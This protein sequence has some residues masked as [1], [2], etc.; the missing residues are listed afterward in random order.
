[1]AT[2]R[3]RGVKQ[4]QAIVRRAGFTVVTKTFETR[5]GAELWGAEVE[6]KMLQGC[7][8]C[9]IDLSRI[10]LGD[11]LIRYREEVAPRHKG[12]RVEKYRI[13][14]LL[15]HPISE[16]FLNELRASHF[17]LYRDEQLKKIK[18]STL[19]KNL[20]QFNQAIETARKEW[21]LIDIRNPIS[22]IRKPTVKNNRSRRLSGHEEEQLLQAF[23]PAIRQP[24]GTYGP[25]IRN[26]FM[27]PVFILAIETAARR[28]ELLK[29]TWNQVDLSDGVAT[30][31][32]TKNGLDREIPLTKKAREILTELK[33]SSTGD[34]VFETTDEAIKLCWQRVIKNLGIENLHFHDL[35]HEAISR[36]AKKV[37]NLIELSKISGHQD[38]K[39]L[40]RYYHISARELVNK[41]G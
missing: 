4:W 1:M 37:P 13:N 18:P 41:I 25:G 31:L 29:L 3:K 40:S 9:S 19:L 35:R 5:L 33:K 34:K 30:F 16:V 39:M 7:Q 17:A 38:L 36:L 6:K 24:D 15:R 23:E 28:G 12:H 11:L 8:P 32:D 20:G 27:K 26:Q 14:G 21:D 10:T 2:I 22:N